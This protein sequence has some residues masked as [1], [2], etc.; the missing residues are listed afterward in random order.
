[1]FIKLL[2]PFTIV[3]LIEL[4]LILLAGRQF[5]VLPTVAAIF[6]TG[7]SGAWLARRQGFELLRRIQRELTLGK[8]PAGELMDGALILAG[9]ILL[10]TPGFFTDLFG[11]ALLLPLT[12]ALFKSLLQR[13]LQRQADRGVIV[14]Q[15]L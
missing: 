11:L 5:G 8:I 10:L 3:P 12:R 15:R 2:V 4:Y 1:M 14:V 9:G 13:W 6:L 7:A